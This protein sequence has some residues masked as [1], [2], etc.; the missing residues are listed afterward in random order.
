LR[1]PSM[2]RPEPFPGLLL[3][4]DSPVVRAALAKGLD[5]RG[6]RVLGGASDPYM[7]RDLIFKLNPD[8]LTLDLQ[9]PNMDGLTFLAKLMAYRPMPVVVLSSFTKANQDLAL[10][11]ME[12]GAVEVFPKPSGPGKG[13][14]L[15]LLAQC[16]RRAA[17]ARPRPRLAPALAASGGVTAQADLKRVVAIGASTGGT[18]AIQSILASLPPV[19]P[20][21]LIVQHMP[22]DFTDAFA[23]R[24]DGLGG[25]RVKEAKDGDPLLPGF[26][27]LAPGGLHMRLEGPPGRMRVAC[28][29]G[30][31]LHYVAPSVDILFHSVAECAGSAGLGVLLTGMGRDGADGLLAMRRSGADTLAQDEASSVV[32]G[33]PGE[34]DKI[35]AAKELVP[36]DRMA[37]RIM[38]HLDPAFRSSCE[39]R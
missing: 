1:R 27:L 18:S 38:D 31:P 2:A 11:A 7:A 33:M 39:T 9:M 30:P 24:L 23:R 22:A 16:V 35:G 15:A 4:D 20:P 37:A 19:F 28:F 36:L 26:A 6:L 8:V 3:V 13:D 34:A 21:L 10:R 14:E 25:I 32:W 5:G 12:L 29:E 17:R